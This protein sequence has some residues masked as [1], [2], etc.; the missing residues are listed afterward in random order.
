MEADVIQSWQSH[1]DDHLHG[2]EGLDNQDF[3]APWSQDGL[4]WARDKLNA[5]GQHL[6]AAAK[7]RAAPPWS[8]PFELIWTVSHP[9]R[10]ISRRCPRLEADAPNIE[11]RETR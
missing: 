8:L 5:T 11:L 2:P 9:H 7:R 1:V 4:D 3:T 10:R 6:G